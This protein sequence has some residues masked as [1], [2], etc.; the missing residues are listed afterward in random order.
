MA[1]L[2]MKRKTM[3]SKVREDFF[4]RPQSASLKSQAIKSG[5]VSIVA[6]MIS[7]AVHMIGVIILAR[8]LQPRDFGLVTMVTAFYLLLTNFGFNG[9][10]E[11]I[12]QKKTVSHT[13]VS[14][15]FWIHA[16]ISLLLMLGFIAAAPIIAAF[17]K[18]PAVKLVV[19]VMAF[20]IMG[21]MLSTHHLALMKRKMEFIKVTTIQVV[22]RVLSL[23]LAVLMAL[24]GFQHWSVVTRQLS[25][26]VMVGIGAWIMCPWIPGLPKKLKGEAGSLIFALQVYGNFTLNYIARNLDK[27]LLGRFY[28][29]KVLGNYDRAYHLASQ[30]VAQLVVPLNNVGLATLS[31]LRDDPDRYRRYYTKALC[32]LAFLGVF[33]SLFLTFTGRDLIFLLLGPGW[34]QAGSVVTAFGPGIGAMIIY[35]TC[36]WIH[37]S[38]AKPDRW[39]RWNIISL[40]ITSAFLAAS[41]PFGPVF[42]A[43]AYSTSYYVLLVPALWYAGRPIEL[44]TIPLLKAIGPYFGSGFVTGI[45]LLGFTEFFPTSTHLFKEL[46]PILRLCIV[47]SFNS[48]IYTAL[49]V[50]FHRSFN[51]VKDLFSFLR[52]LIRRR[53]VQ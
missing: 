28:G 32:V 20:G 53:Q 33:G 3:S 46:S 17:Y 22:A 8:L 14:N 51:P 6:Q 30:P 48:V 9:F 10:T 4:A 2:F 18:E 39:L 36:S 45:I 24:N 12:I 42:V 5:G 34:E 43:V 23:V 27:I 31:R 7:L 21:R 16:F 41:A 26:I 13:E 29:S 25:E 37:L 40:V 19:R 15:L 1:S 47:I 38:L 11:Y 50:A 44:K 49:V 35:S 52:T